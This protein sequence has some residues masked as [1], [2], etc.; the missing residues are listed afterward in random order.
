VA[1]EDLV[2]GAVAELY[3]A[4]PREFVPRRTE[5]AAQARAAGDV[6]AAKQIAGLRKPTQSAWVVN[7]LARA[8]PEAA[9]R[10]SELGAE[11]RQAQRNLDGTALRE[12]SVRRRELVDDLARQA[13]AAV[14]QPA[15]PAALREEVTGTLGA[16]LADPAVARELAAGTLSRPVRSDGF[17]AAGPLLSAVPES[18]EAELAWARPAESAPVRTRPARPGAKA[19]VAKPAAARPST[20][21]SSARARAAAAE[22]ARR[23]QHRQVLA[24][25][26]KA[27]A[28]ADRDAAA[29]TQAE[30][31]LERTVERLEE[32]LADARQELTQARSKARR[33]RTTSRQLRQ[34]LDRLQP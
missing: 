2:S 20:E 15:P 10:L 33:A 31:D 6:P 17:A 21:K 22:K 5:L 29:A 9:D 34:S 16:A 18:A 19:T 25:A 14:G 32:Q 27:A 28:Q 23:E 30:Q 24:E 8:A 11:L 4:D 1:S 26:R 3:G 13:F 7:Q 12:L